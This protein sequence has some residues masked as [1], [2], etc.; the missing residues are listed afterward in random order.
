VKKKIQAEGI[1]CRELKGGKAVTL[2][3]RGPYQE[4]SKS[5]RKI[6][7]YLREHNLKT[8]LPNREQYLKGPGMIFRGNPKKYVTRLMLLYE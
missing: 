7:E 8:L 4:L 3:H 2:I 1:D 5:Y 6:Y